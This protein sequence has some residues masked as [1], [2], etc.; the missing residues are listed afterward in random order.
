MAAEQTSTTTTAITA[1]TTDMTTAAGGFGLT[2]TYMR[3]RDQGHLHR[4]HDRQGDAGHN[5]LLGTVPVPDCRT[6]IQVA[7]EGTCMDATATLRKRLG[8]MLVEAGLLSNDDA[9]QAAREAAPPAASSA[10]S[11]SRRAS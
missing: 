9:E 5:R 6:A 8:Q 1:A 11:S 7:A 3:R 4:R 10:T 2:P